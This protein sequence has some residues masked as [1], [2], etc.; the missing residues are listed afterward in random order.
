MAGLETSLS[1]V[2]DMYGNWFL[3]YASYVILERAV[4]HINDGLKPV[5]RRIL[6][7]LKSMD[8]G[9][10]HKVA[11]VAGRA[12]AF[13]PHGNVAI[14][15]ALIQLGQ[16]GLLVD[17]QGNWG[18]PLTGDPPAAAR[19]IECK[20]SAFALEVGFSP[21]IT[22]WQASY[23]G[24]NKEPVTLPV[25]FPLVLAQGIEGIAV[26]L[27]CKILSHNFIELIEA[28]IDTLRGKKVNV[29]PDFFSG[30]LMDATE[31]NEGLRGGKIRVR[32]RIE[33]AKRNLLIIR[34]I[35]YGTTTVGLKASILAAN[36]KGKI[37]ISKVDDLT[38]EN[39]EI[40]VTLPSGTDADQAIQGLFAFSDCEVSISPNSCV[41]DDNKPRFLS[42]N[43]LI[44]A[45]AF[46][47][48]ELLRQEL[49]IRLGE[50][51][52]KWHFASLEKI[53]I[54]K[55]IYRD[56]EE[57]ETWKAVVKAIDKG[58]KPHVKNLRRIVTEEDIVRLTEIK[59]KR[60]SKYNKFKANEQLKALEDEI[61]QV[62][63]HLKQLTRYAVAW[64]K[65]LQKKYSK[66]RERRTEITTFSKVQASKVVI[67]NEKL[68]LNK[69]DGFVGTTLKKDDLVGPCSSLNDFIVF[70]SDGTM[71]V[72]RVA[73]K[74]F[75]G[76]NPQH[77]AIYRKD[78][79]V[80]YTMIYRDGRGGACYAKKFTV[81]GV[82]RDKIYDLTRGKSSSRLLW[83]G[84]HKTED[85]TNFVVRA[86]F[87]AEGLRLR[88]L[89][90]DFDFGSL[91]TKARGVVGLQV[92]KKPVQRIA[93]PQGS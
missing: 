7:V 15:D 72:S 28:S 56:I 18:D 87:K 46:H 63:K 61:A 19:Y 69:S 21:K 3:D 64:F 93:K 36:D 27:A 59:I 30:G 45:S 74:V 41:I 71:T 58:L 82:T 5:Q 39:V 42:V 26:G 23:D 24:R 77:V 54:E 1:H 86:H 22:E 38:A 60:I 11:N 17:T 34:E 85:D 84:V 25:K 70:R 55:R 16:K 80:F 78:T 66:G 48:K 51:E 81:S 91:E 62:N 14:E 29:L 83:F 10:L 68:F 8:D 33:K 52:E 43:D 79:P 47:T 44:K 13:H 49:E 89:S 73:A 40:Q 75:V 6:H 4:P 57:S 67:A 12:T 2:D 31:Y 32:A 35:P 20:L 88:N 65:N 53:F 37:K 50:L 9:R 76:K 92:T 90:T